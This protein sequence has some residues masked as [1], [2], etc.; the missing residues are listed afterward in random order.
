[1]SHIDRNLSRGFVAL[2]P[3]MKTETADI[4]LQ[5]QISNRQI[6]KIALPIAAAIL[7]PQVNFITNNIFLGGLG[8]QP[9]AVAGIT[10][11]YY[12]I[13]GMMGFGLNSG[14]Q[15]LISRRAGE[16]RI[17]EIGN[18]FNQGVRIALLFAILGIIVTYA[19][20]P[21]V[22]RLSLHNESNVRMAINFLYIRIWGLP[23][24]YL[25][26][27]RNALLVGTN[28]SR[29]LI[30]GT[31]AETI[32]NIVFEYALIYGHFGF[33]PLGF[34][35]AAIASIIAE[36]TGLFVI[37]GVMYH[38]GLSDRLQ[39]F[40]KHAYNAANTKLIIAQ[41]LPLILQYVISISAWE[42][43]YILIEHHGERDLALSNTMRNIFGFFGCVTW[44]FASTTNSMVGNII[45]QGLQHRVVE[46]IV[47]IMKLS[48]GFAG[49]IFL[50]LNI[51]P[52][53]LLQVYNQG[54]DFTSAGIPV[55]RVVSVAIPLM[56]ASTIWL[57]AVV[58]T[59]NSKVNLAFEAGAIV[60]YSIYVYILLEKLHVSITIA[61]T[62][63]WI[64]WLSL[65]IPSFLYIRSG[66]WKHR[67][68]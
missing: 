3:L 1:M 63:E 6:L 4:N 20:A 10:G 36:I 49:I 30:I 5:V 12:L 17:Q 59:G 23:F 42:F 15:S 43:F 38:K 35:G 55:V 68:I 60:I 18:M 50:F 61:W 34:N 2:P 16:N 54:N 25:Y 13:F 40:K 62:A 53:I 32:T 47:K 8:E 48:L 45:G 21:T 11:V 28:N 9:L 29:Y 51:A 39:L 41:S 26:Q 31:L 65:L 66:K 52:Y 67:I 56:A 46:I 64:Y 58:G 33:P 7:V 19:F 37:F 57:S 44:A 14:L 22:F 27:M 24:L